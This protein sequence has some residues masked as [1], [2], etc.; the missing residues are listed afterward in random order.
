MAWT[1]ELAIAML[2]VVDG[3]TEGA[4]RAGLDGFDDCIDRR[5][6]GLNPWFLLHA[7]D[8]GQPGRADPG[9]GTNGPVVMY[10][11]LLADVVDPLVPFPIAG[12]LVRK[13]R[14]LVRAVAEGLFFERPQRQRAITFF[15]ES[16][17]RRGLSGYPARKP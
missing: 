2:D 1:A 14:G 16:F 4:R 11:D 13:S 3:V 9:V 8:R 7:P 12:F 15:E 10:R 6:V 5:A 17:R